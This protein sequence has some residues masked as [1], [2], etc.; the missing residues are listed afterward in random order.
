MILDTFVMPKLAQQAAIVLAVVAVAV[1]DV[2]LKKA[3]DQGSLENILRSPWLFCAIGLYL[4]QI[5]LFV[6]A[7]FRG[8]ELSIIG[9]MQIAFYAL[10][11]LAAGVFLYN[12]N[13]TRIQAIGMLLAFSGVVLINWK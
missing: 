5:G 9:S 13:P 3:A 7:F 6:I 1:A 8:W 11:I 10:I 12:E 4:L 2:L